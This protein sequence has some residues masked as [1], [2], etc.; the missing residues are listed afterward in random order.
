MFSKVQ[1]KDRGGSGRTGGK[2]FNLGAGFSHVRADDEP[3]SVG[4]DTH[5]QKHVT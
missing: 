5:Q 4:R 1:F 3:F 2:K